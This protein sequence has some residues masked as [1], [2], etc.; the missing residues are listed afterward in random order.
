MLIFLIFI[1]FQLSKLPFGDKMLEDL[2]KQFSHN[3]VQ[4]LR[5]HQNKDYL[6]KELKHCLMNFCEVNMPNS[7]DFIERKEFYGRLKSTMKLHYPHYPRSY[8]S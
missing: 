2:T 7:N 6:N 5:G 1:V 4:F 3:L 8:V